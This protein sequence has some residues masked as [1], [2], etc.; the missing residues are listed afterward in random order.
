MRR[1]Q[2]KVFSFKVQSGIGSDTDTALALTT[3]MAIPQHQHQ[4]YMYSRAQ[5]ASQNPSPKNRLEEG[6]G[7]ESDSP[8]VPTQ[9][10]GI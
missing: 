8:A 6:I 4:L 1:A 9:A 7:F 10:C 2:R 5:T 3:Y